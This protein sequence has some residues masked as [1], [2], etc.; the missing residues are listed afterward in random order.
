MSIALV[1]LA[2]LAGF[3]IGLGMLDNTELIPAEQIRPVK[4]IILQPAATK[5]LRAYPGHIE[6][7][8]RVELSFRV[9]GPLVSLNVK[10]GQLVVKGE[11]LARIDPRDYKLNMENLD[12]S[13]A[14]ARAKFKSMAHARPEDLALLNA[15]LVAAEARCDLAKLD[16]GRFSELLKRDSATQAEYDASK[17]VYI[18]AQAERDRAKQELAKGQAGARHEDIAAMRANIAALEAQRK[19]TAAALE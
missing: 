19:M 4:T 7:A 8:Q 11:I 14:Q 1:V 5:I 12:S 2:S 3:G 13:L 18:I 6:A 10:P 17:S 9:S 15:A 16:H